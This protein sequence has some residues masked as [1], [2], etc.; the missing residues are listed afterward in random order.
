MAT[1][2]FWTRFE[3]K[4][5]LALQIP[6]IWTTLVC[7]IV[8]LLL[9]GAGQYRDLQL[10]KT[11]EKIKS[12]P[13]GNTHS[14]SPASKNSEVEVEVLSSRCLNPECSQCNPRLVPHF[15]PRL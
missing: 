12:T 6:H 15:E 9:L 10:A 8:E 13:F 14:N 11:F 3:K 5:V 1:T 2:V 4:T 7:F